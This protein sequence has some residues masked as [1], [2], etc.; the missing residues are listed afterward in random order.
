MLVACDRCKRH[1]SVREEL[2]PFCR[3]PGALS[4]LGA[5]ALSAGVLLAGCD[6]G[7]TK[8][9]PHES[10]G[11]AAVAKRPYATVHGMVK[12]RNGDPVINTILTISSTDDPSGI[13]MYSRTLPTDGVGKFT[14]DFLPPGNYV[15]GVMYN[16]NV[17]PM[18]LTGEI[19][20]PLT[21]VAGED[22]EIDFSVEVRE[23]QYAP[24]Y[25]APP[26]SRRVV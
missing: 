4:K 14:F 23:M 11:S 26:G 21:V 6:A 13:H 5:A 2:C 18:E 19:Q 1:I 8:Q 20:Q 24:P 15:I 7:K 22:K 10:Q 9:P 12:A 17:A 16:R 25:G 3:Q